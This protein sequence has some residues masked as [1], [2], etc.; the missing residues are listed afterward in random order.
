[1]VQ[2]RPSRE[3]KEHALSIKSEVLAVAKTEVKLKF[4]DLAFGLQI[5]DIKTRGS[6]SRVERGSW[7]LF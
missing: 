3:N 1:M 5:I 6:D 4:T 2:Y 7:T